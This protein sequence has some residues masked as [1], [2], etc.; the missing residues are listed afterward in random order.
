[1]KQG[2][3]A[4][5]RPTVLVQQSRRHAGFEHTETSLDANLQP[6]ALRWLEFVT[7]YSNNNITVD[8]NQFLGVLDS[9]AHAVPGQAL[10]SP[11]ACQR[12]HPGWS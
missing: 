11:A 8:L 7:Q 1:M 5:S 4:A 6:T 2:E 9:L 10:R 12:E 3:S